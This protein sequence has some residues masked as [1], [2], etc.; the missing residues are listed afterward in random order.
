MGRFVTPMTVDVDMA[1]GPWQ[2][3]VLGTARWNGWLA[4]HIRPLQDRHGRWSTPYEGDPG[5]PDLIIARR[6]VVLLT[7]LKTKRGQLS[8]DQRTWLDHAG[9]QGRLWRP[10][11]W[12]EV[13]KELTA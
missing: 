2:S 1:E 6:S 8:N 9:T 5:L 7:E 10:S 3:L 11:D 12:P 13:F 4:V